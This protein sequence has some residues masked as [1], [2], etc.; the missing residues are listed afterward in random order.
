MNSNNK[1]G[2]DDIKRNSPRK[3]EVPL[4]CELAVCVDGGYESLKLN[5]IVFF[6]YPDLS[7]FI[8]CKS[9]ETESAPR[10]V[11]EFRGQGLE[12]YTT[13]PISGA[14]GQ[15]HVNGYFEMSDFSSGFFSDPEGLFSVK[16]THESDKGFWFIAEFEFFVVFYLNEQQVKYSI[17]SEAFQ[18]Q[19]NT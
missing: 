16:R 7:F 13:Y 8:R 1:S 9:K 2:S 3:Q 11:L 5:D 12:D 6:R 4:I 14:G 18:A 10:A 17:K 15:G 19:V